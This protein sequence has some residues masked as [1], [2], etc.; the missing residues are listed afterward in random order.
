MKQLLKTYFG[1]DEFRPLQEEIINNVL[2]KKDTFVLM[3]TGG[4]KSLCYQLPALKFDGLTLVVSPLIALMKDQ[5]DALKANGIAA[6]YI[7]SSLPYS[8]IAQIQKNASEGKVK[9][10]YL[11]PE[12]LASEPFR[13]F[14]QTLKID[15]I[16]IDEAHCISEWG[17]D[18]RHDYRNLKFFRKQFP[19][20]PIIALTATATAK[21]RED[22]IEQLSLNNPKICVSSFDR[23]NLSFLITRKKN[24]FDKLVRI[25][26][27]HKNK[28]AIIYCFSRKDT[29]QIAGDLKLEGFNA[30]PYHAGLNSETRKRNQELFIKDEAQIIVATIAFGMGIDKPDV[31][32]VVHYTFPKT[33]E[34]YYQ[35][36]GRAGRDGLPSECVMFYSYGDRRKHDFFID[37]IENGKE[38]SGALKKLDQIIEYCEQTGC[39]R[40][41]ILNYFGEEYIFS[42]NVDGENAGCGACDICLWPQEKFDATEIA[43]KILSCVIKTGNRFGKKYIVDV[44]KGKSTEQIIGNGH[45]AISVFGIVSDFTDEEIKNIIRSLITLN[46][47]Q[48]SEGKYPTLSVTKK[49][50]NFLKQKESLEISKAREDSKGLY[51]NVPRQEMEYDRGLFEKLCVLRKQIADKQGIPPFVVFS[52][53]S[54]C[55]MAHYFPSDKNNFSKIEGV[56]SR[57]LESFGGAFLEVINNYAK[58]NNIF[59]LEVPDRG[60]RR[61]N[62]IK[63]L[64]K[65]GRSRYARTKEMVLQ[66]IPL[67]EIAKEEGFTEGTIAS[68]IEKLLEAGED[69]D[70]AYLKPTREK[71]EK[72]KTAFE[73]CGDEKLKPVFEFLKEEYSYDEIRLVKLFLK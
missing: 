5:V 69:I 23:E 73:K 64:V 56:G 34:G 27:K 26:E 29:E 4:G 12:R 47:L 11:A 3:P 63:R 58:E 31:R 54:L 25:L 52:D 14:L 21:V 44:L 18:F 35:E 72:I 49:G 48:V 40:K 2:N 46:F 67:S 65:A 70:I 57:K 51:E 1:Y 19:R 71:F 10:L 24:A 61:I 41:F 62:K 42:E 13:K 22:V 9:I 20:I 6:E 60:E 16:A 32:L 45:D 15:L 28:S 38:R 59:S 8:E 17:H 30:L 39:R 68:H 7:N 55:E 53:I 37:Q 33:L 66:K 43:Q 36:V 50:I